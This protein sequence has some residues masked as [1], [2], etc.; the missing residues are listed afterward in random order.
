M[1][2]STVRRTEPRPSQSGI[3]SW[4]EIASQT[5]WAGAA[6]RTVCST[7]CVSVRG[8]LLAGRGRKAPALVRRRG[9]PQQLD[10]E[11]IRVVHVDDA[12]ARHVQRPAVRSCAGRAGASVEL[13]VLAPAP[14]AERDV[15]DALVRD[16]VVRRARPPDRIEVLDELD[17]HAAGG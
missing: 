7:A 8:R 9:H 14:S 1:H 5:A 16:P 2:R 12:A 3:R 4:S 6:I 15:Q 17:E 11:P 13:A 10:R